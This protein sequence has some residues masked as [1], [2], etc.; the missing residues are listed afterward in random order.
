MDALAGELGKTVDVG[1]RLN[2]NRKCGDWRNLLVDRKQKSFGMETREFIAGLSAMKAARQLR[3]GALM[4]HS[5]KSFTVPADYVFMLKRLFEIG[6]F[7]RGQG[8][9]V[10]EFNLGGGI[11]EE[12]MSVYRLADFGRAIG[13]AYLKQSRRCGLSPRLSFELGKSLVGSAAILVGRVL[14]VRKGWV[15]VDIS[16]SDYGFAFPFRERRV[17]IANKKNW[18]LETTASVCSGNLE[19]FDVMAKKIALPS[20]GQGDTVVLSNVGAYSL[21]LATQFIRPRCAVYLLTEGGEE[22]LIRPRETAA[23]VAARQVWKF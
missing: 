11:P 10:N 16:R 7:L 6:V 20:V 5:A 22:V 4:A 15:I 3:L 18:P 14:E 21:P 9:I 2:I 1:I 23:D 19:K 12:G 17:L 13:D 8:M